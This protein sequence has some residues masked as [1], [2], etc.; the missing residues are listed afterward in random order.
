MQLYVGIDPGYGV[1]SPTGVVVFDELGVI[2][3]SR[4]VSTGILTDEAEKLQYIARNVFHMLDSVLY[5]E[6]HKNR[7]TVFVEQFV[8][9]GKGGQTLQRLT[10]AIVSNLPSYINKVRYVQN[11]TVKKIVGG[12]GRADKKT[13]GKGVYEWVRCRNP[14]TAVGVKTWIKNEEWDLLDS[15]AIGITGLEKASA[16]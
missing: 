1:A 11:T 6:R 15:L 13:V 12:H 2:Y 8:M 3:L 16:L 7:V 5:P 10:G 9:K 14:A 4:L